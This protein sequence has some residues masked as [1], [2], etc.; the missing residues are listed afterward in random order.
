MKIL[1]LLFLTLFLGKGCEGDKKQDIETA[2]IEYVA[3]TRG[4]YQK[5]TI[6][7]QMVSISNDRSGKEKIE[8]TKI[9]DA[10]WKILIDLFQDLNLD[11]IKD[12][13][14]PT[15]KRLYD[16]AAIANIKITYKGITYES[17]SFDHGFPPYEIKKLVNKINSFA[18]QKDEN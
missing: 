3:N 18:K 9:S 17:P 16:G 6:E 8:P 14:S 13:K 10:D 7:K 11:E 1:S 2:V 5:I 15:E 12:L 4:F